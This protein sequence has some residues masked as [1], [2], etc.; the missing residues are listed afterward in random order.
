MA[1]AVDNEMMFRNHQSDCFF[2]PEGNLLTLLFCIVVALMRLS[3]GKSTAGELEMDGLDVSSWTTSGGVYLN[4]FQPT[5][6]L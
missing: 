2:G 5:M 4:S 1:T 3:L 6:R